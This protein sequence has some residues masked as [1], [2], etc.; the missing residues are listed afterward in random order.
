MIIIKII[1]PLLFIILISSNIGC[2]FKGPLYLSRQVIGS[3]INN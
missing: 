3:C 2:G 1:F